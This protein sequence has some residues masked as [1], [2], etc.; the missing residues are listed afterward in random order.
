V[1]RALHLPLAILAGVVVR[2]PFWIEALRTPVD[3]DTAIIGLMARHLGEGTTMW[4]QPYGSPLDAWVAAPFVAAMGATAEPLRLCYALLGLLLIPV[5]YALARAL[6]PSA[7]LPAA[8]LMACPPPYFLLLSALPPP[9]YP[10]TLILCGLLLLLAIRAGDRLARPERPPVPGLVAWGALAGLALWTHLMSA[11]VVAASGVF[12]FLRARGRRGVLVNALVP[13]LLASSPWWTGLPEGRE[14]TRIVKVAGREQGMLEHLGEVV[15]QLH[16][17]LGGLLGTHVPVVADSVESVVMAPRGAAAAIVL[18]YGLLIVLA[19]RASRG[20]GPAGLLVAT[21]VLTLA[22]FPFPVRSAPHTIRFLTP[23]YL[24]VLV[25]VVWLP[26][27]SDRLRRAWVVVLLLATLHLAGGVRLLAA[28]RS[29]DRAEQPF[30]LPDLSPVRRALEARRLRHVY[31]SYGPAYRLTYESGESIV[32]S[33]P[34]NERFLHYPLPYLDE[35]R[36]AKDVAWVLTPG[37]PGELPAPEVFESMLRGMGGTWRRS[38]AGLAVVYHDF[39]PPF[40]PKVE[41]LASAGLA[42]DGDLRTSLHPDVAAPTTFALGAPRKL[43]GLTLV[44]ALEGPRLL[45]SMDV[46]VSADGITFEVVARRRRRLEREDLRWVNGHP[47]VVLDHDLIAIPLGGRPV[48]SVRIRPEASADP[49]TLGE[50]LVHPAEDP[51]R[52][53]PWPEWLKEG[54][55][56]GERRRALAANE[57]KDRADWYYRMLLVARR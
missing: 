27:A 33:Q 31:A 22:A 19:V 3:G 2:V 46:E 20:R 29:A 36:F 9:L 40:S 57:K 35:V 1:R 14:A 7:A 34:W 32:G 21:A 12:L 43:D 38:D 26:V 52:R 5:A 10:T 54:L 17:T 55:T 11:S 45:R 6:H 4:G 56:W 25:L 48:V 28:W 15:P 13:L 8:V 30:L 24:P 53:A 49:W 23:L 37:L 50:V 16:Q 51:A 44:A 41:P 42:G 18:A 47:Q 39:V